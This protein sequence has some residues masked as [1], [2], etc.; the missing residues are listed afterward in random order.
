MDMR[1]CAQMRSGKL[2]E[3]LCIQF[4]RKNTECQKSLPAPIVPKRKRPSPGWRG[5][6][7]G[8]MAKYPSPPPQGE[9]VKV[10]GITF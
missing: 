2:T 6:G 9:G 10:V 5:L 8:I 1:T 4:I 3:A 7:G